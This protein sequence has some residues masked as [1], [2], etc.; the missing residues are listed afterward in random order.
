MF[1]MLASAHE[2][3][4]VAFKS[5]YSQ[6]FQSVERFCFNPVTR[7]EERREVSVLHPCM[8]RGCGHVHKCSP[9]VFLRDLQ[10]HAFLEMCNCVSITIN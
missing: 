4:E 1:R 6:A 10:V 3:L 9:A 5:A 8:F 2:H 7:A